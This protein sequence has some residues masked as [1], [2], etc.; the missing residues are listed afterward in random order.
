[1]LVSPLVA[2]ALA[3]LQTA[4]PAPLQPT[5][6]QNGRLEIRR[7]AP[8]SEKPLV[9]VPTV[10]RVELSADYANPFDPAQIKLDARVEPPSGKSYLLPG[11]FAQDFTRELKDGKEVLTPSGDGGWNLRLTPREAGTH[12]ILLVAQD[13][14]GTSISKSL[15][16]DAQA[17]PSAPGF[18]K[19]AERDRRFFETDAGKAYWPVGANVGWGGEAGTY[20]YD[21]WI[22]SYAKEGLSLMRVW[23]SP[24][25][26][27]FATERKELGFGRFSMANAWRLDQTIREAEA[28]GIRLQLCLDSYN[29]LRDKDAYPFWEGAV[30]NRR[31]GGPLDYPT[32]FWGS[33][34]MDKEYLARLRYLVARYAADPGVFAW[35]LWNEADLTRDF[36]VDRARAWHAATVAS[37][38]ALDPYGHLVTTSFANTQG[39]KDIDML[40]GLDFIVTHSY[41]A[42]D[43]VNPVAVQQSRKAGWGKPHM[44]QEIGA[45]AGGASKG[46]TRGYELHDPMWASLATASAG[47]AMG[48]WWDSKTEPL[49]LYGLY[50]AL[51]RFVKGI[52]FPRE[53]FRQTRPVFGYLN[54]PKPYPRGDMVVPTLA[55]SWSKANS[56][57]ARRIRVDEDGASASAP[58]LFHGT[59]NHPELHNPLTMVTRFDRRTRFDVLVGGVSG[60]GGAR[61]AVSLDGDRLLTRDFPDPDGDRGTETLEGYRGAYGFEIPAGRHTL[62][63]A[64]VGK[65]WMHASLRFKGTTVQKA[66]ALDAWAAVGETTVVLWARNSERTLARILAEG[67]SVGGTVPPTYAKLE[68][69]AS[70]TYDVTLWD[71]WKGV[72]IGTTTRKVP[73]SGIITIP[74]PEIRHDL[75]VKA[76]LRDAK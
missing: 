53:G 48:W 57:R 36:P 34:T 41:G 73:L 31:N 4:P 6:A 28:R 61:L 56:N 59:A 71:T 39:V 25:W 46:D 12:R 47:S 21:R 62:E 16:L 55:A 42:A 63:V 24:G 29:M 65:D 30:W 2:S 40:P 23:L 60:Y 49:G 66:P 43:I 70:G 26:A 7:L 8:E 17:N 27:T 52:D 14:T 1:M 50:G 11:Y 67:E 9:G 13:R 54:K 19:I 5:Y 38:K 64:N 22:E 58:A 75:A 76:V 18:V 33:A 44:A 3:T 68:G 37:L 32:D 74:L 20:D 15:T 69:L 10:V 35:E 72:A 45:D 51:A